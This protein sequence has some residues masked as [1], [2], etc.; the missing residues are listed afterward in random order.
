[1]LPRT[2]HGPRYARAPAPPLRPMALRP[3]WGQALMQG[4]GIEQIGGGK[5]AGEGTVLR[6][7]VDHRLHDAQVDVFEKRCAPH[8]AHDRDVDLRGAADELGGLVV[9]LI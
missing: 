4:A 8:L 1:P 6:A 2:S 9:I 3:G 7:D 5:T